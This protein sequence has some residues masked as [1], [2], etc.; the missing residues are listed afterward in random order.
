MGLKN[1]EV[2]VR[3]VRV[4]NFYFCDLCGG[5][6]VMSV[7]VW[8]GCGVKFFIFLFCLFFIVPR[9]ACVLIISTVTLTLGS[10]FLVLG[11]QKFVLVMES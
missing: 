9:W 4:A 7:G 1:D 2:M 6:G 11:I 8:V 5:G 10:N 3:L